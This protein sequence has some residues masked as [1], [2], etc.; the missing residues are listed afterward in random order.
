MRANIFSAPFLGALLLALQA[1]PLQAGISP[2]AFGS[3]GGMPTLAPML[4][5]AIPAVVSISAT[6]ERSAESTTGDN[7]LEG[8]DFQTAEPRDPLKR[9]PAGQ[10][11][12]VII[13]H[14]LGYI[15]TNHH[16]IEGS[17][18][19]EVTLEDGRSFPAQTIGS[20]QETDIALLRIQAS[21]L[22]SIPLGNSNTLRVGDFVI[23]IGNPFGLGNTATSG[24]VS[25]LG[26][27]NL[28]LERF[29]AFIQTDASINVGNS[30]GALINLNGELVG[31]NTAILAPNGNGSVGIGFAIPVNMA[32]EISNQLIQFG[33]VQRGHLGV[34]TK[35][36]SSNMA[37]S[38]RIPQGQGVVI[39][40]VES[41]SPAAEAR[42]R[43]GDILTAVNGHPIESPAQLQT[44]I[45]LFPVGKEVKLSLL[46]G[47]HP[48]TL[49]AT[50][51]KPVSRTLTGDALSANLSG[52]ELAPLSAEQN[53]HYPS[54]GI[55]VTEVD[56]RQAGWAL[57]LRP[58]DVIFS[59][60]RQPV[61]S[62]KEAKKAAALSEKMVIL[63]VYRGEKILEMIMR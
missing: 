46:R 56:P 41:D 40:A 31:I 12:G 5:Q 1:L 7:K 30:G 19:I 17:E 20:D 21:N 52:V 34:T 32:K 51:R 15:L 44:T 3:R 57:G 27:S 4:E 53:N 59:F 37:R 60:N 58:N 45:S 10:G 25:A 36:L 39:T 6:L 24:I 2:L 54:G 55:A 11:S 14:H 33:G 23:A 50:I 62:L 48:R 61:T 63:R 16:L 22:H 28:G 29:E 18:A 9:N 13:N 38:L 8:F 47:N 43:K 42:V 35:P 26:R 49:F